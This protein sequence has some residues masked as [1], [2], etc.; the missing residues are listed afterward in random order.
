MSFM[1]K[2]SFWVCVL[3]AISLLI[4]LRTFFGPTILFDSHWS[5]CSSLS[6]IHMNCPGRCGGLMISALNSG[7]SRLGSSP[8]Q[9]ILLC[10]WARHFTLT[11]PLS[12]QVSKGI[13]QNLMLGVTLQWTSIPSRQSKNSPTCF[14]LRKPG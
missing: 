9:E 8:G 10:L 13:L 3:K 1:S 6:I 11:V 4:N 5:T 14:M 2:S 12:T 7:L